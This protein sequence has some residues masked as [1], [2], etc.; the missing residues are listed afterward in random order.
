MGA[1]RRSSSARPAGLTVG[2]LAIGGLIA[3][4]LWLDASIVVAVVYL[5]LSAITFGVYAVDK[6]AAGTSRRR[7]PERT[8]LLLGFAAGWPGGVLAQQ[9]L[10]HKTRKPSFQLRF[11]A[12]VAANTAVLAALLVVLKLPTF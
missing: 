11:W 10:R 12:T 5:V 4:G 1:P 6:S 3:L 2:L 8:L 7:V 9:T